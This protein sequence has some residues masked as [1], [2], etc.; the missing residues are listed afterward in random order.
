KS[1]TAGEGVM[2]GQMLEAPIKIMTARRV[3]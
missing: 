2:K 1:A 3:P